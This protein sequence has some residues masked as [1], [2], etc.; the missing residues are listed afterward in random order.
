MATATDGYSRLVA[1]LKII[2]PLIALAILSTLFLVS[3]TID[4][5]QTIPYA[6][7]D[8]QD[9]A[10]NQRIGAPSYSGMT[11]DG[12]AISFQA[13]SARPGADPEGR[14]TAERPTARIDLPTG[15]GIVLIADQGY[16]DQKANIAALDGN[17]RLE[18]T[19]GYVIETD[20][21]QTRLDAT[22]MESGGPVNGSGPMGNI[23][24]GR[25]ILTR[26]EDGSYVLRFEM[27]VNLVYRPGT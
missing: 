1:W 23:S 21:A 26:V 20:M 12:S 18:S 19:D 14:V 27:G 8:V 10:R 13:D 17:V 22:L 3:R 25:V 24:A 7:V 11:R 4:P 15:R 2:L 9:L 6:D 16:V 5:S